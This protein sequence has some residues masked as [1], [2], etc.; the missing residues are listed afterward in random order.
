MF[1]V[2]SYFR[3]SHLQNNP[4]IMLKFALLSQVQTKLSFPNH[5]DSPPKNHTGT[6]AVRAH[7]WSSNPLPKLPVGSNR[8][9]LSSE[10][11]KQ[12]A[13]S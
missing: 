1:T 10:M 6:W 2:P 8:T 13:L 5:I 11:Q 4:Q 7:C 9:Q 3:V 12:L